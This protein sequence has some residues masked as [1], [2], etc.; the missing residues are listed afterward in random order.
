MPQKP[1]PVT[2]KVIAK[3]QLELY[4]NQLQDIAESFKSPTL[5]IRE[6]RLKV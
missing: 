4:D 3:K 5:K 1:I 2:K 6:Y